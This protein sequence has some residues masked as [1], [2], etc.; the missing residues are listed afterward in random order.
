MKLKISLLS[1]A[2]LP[3]LALAML[4]ADAEARPTPA[5]KSAAV[6]RAQA[7]V[8]GTAAPRLNRATGDAFAARP[9]SVVIDA[10]GTEHVRFQRTW[11][12]GLPVIGGDFVVHSRNGR[13]VDVSQT[14]DTAVRPVNTRAAFG[15]GYA[16]NAATR[17]FGL[18]TEDRARSRQV[19]YA[20][21]GVEPV[22][23]HEVV[24]AGTR[25]D[26]TPTLMHY[27]VSAVDGRILDKWDEIHT[28]RPGRD[29]SNCGNGV[30]ANGT[31]NT[32]TA[33]TVALGTANCGS[34]YQL[35]DISR[36]GGTTTNMGMRQIGMGT[37]FVDADNTWGNGSL[38]SSQSAGAEAHYGVALTWD[39]FL[40]EHGRNGIADDGVGAVARVHYGR[41]YVNAFWSDSCFCMTF[42]DGDNGVNY[43][44]LTVIDVAA[45]EMTHG[46]TSRTADL[47]Y[48]GESGGL[49][50]ATSDIFGAMV[51]FYANN[52]ADP[53]DYL[54]GEEFIVGNPGDEAL[55]YM[56]K[57]SLDGA[58]YD[59]YEPGLGSDDVHYTSG[60]ANRFFYLLAEGAVVPAGF[61]AGT[62]FSLTPADLV[63][64]GNTTH[65]G[66]GRAKAG[67][68]WYRALTTY[69][70]SN[71]DYAGARAAT[72]QA[73]AELY[74]A[75]SAE[76]LAV[77]AAWDSVLVSN[78]PD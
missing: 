43:Y 61:G 26:Q 16:I 46:I 39:Y 27:I 52:A 62:S 14:L 70:T 4:P 51:E 73:A 30:A 5:Q 1:A 49:N 67:Q 53:G 77:S 8:D 15:S 63:C 72:E 75:D 7:L 33:G 76:E 50:E 28:A 13:L 54:I 60:V 29:N 10:N 35:K 64:D 40:D 3:V 44:P 2:I 38:S 48:S 6:A 32:I 20:R 66:I 42:G 25:A 37:V 56:F 36:G 18:R 47:I 58:S 74:G 11:G 78:I 9:A 34:N 22:L 12:N 55:R 17:A 21:G 65:A 24:L 45:H 23:A 31:G 41:N 69:M 59:C 68:I 71:T 19:V 57:P